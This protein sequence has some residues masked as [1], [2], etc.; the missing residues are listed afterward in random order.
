MPAPLSF[1]PLASAFDGSERVPPL[2]G[3]KSHPS[4]PLPKPGPAAFSS[5][6]N[7]PACFPN[8]LGHLSYTRGNSSPDSILP[9]HFLNS[10]PTRNTVAQQPVSSS[11]SSNMPP[12]HVPR[13]DFGSPTLPVHQ[14]W[15]TFDTALGAIRGAGGRHIDFSSAAYPNFTAI[16]QS[17]RNSVSSTTGGAQ[18]PSRSTEEGPASTETAPQTVDGYACTSSS[19]LG[20]FSTSAEGLAYPATRS[21]ALLPCSSSGLN[22]YQPQSIPQSFRHSFDV[23][24]AGGSP[25]SPTL[26]Q[27]R[28]RASMLEEDIARQHKNRGYY[29]CPVV[30]DSTRSPHSTIAM[31]PP[32]SFPL[33]TITCL[34]AS[35]GQKSYGNEKRFLNPPPMVRVTGSLHRLSSYPRLVVDVVSDNGIYCSREH[36]AIQS[37]DGSTAD[38][39]ARYYLRSLHV[40]K[41][42]KAKTFRL[43]LSLHPSDRPAPPKTLFQ[44]GSVRKAEPIETTEDLNDALASFSSA[45]MQI[46]SKPSKK[47]VRARSTGSCLFDE[48]T[49]ALFNRINAQT[50]RTTFAV[51]EEG[52]LS[53]RAYEWT[54]FKIHV[55]KR[56]EG[57]EDTDHDI[58]HSAFPRNQADGGPEA[59][60]YGSE[61]VL[62]DLMTGSTSE[63]MI[64]RKVE[65]GHVF[66]GA[67]GRVAQLQKLALARVSD[68][69]Y[70]IYLSP[71]SDGMDKDGFSQHTDSYTYASNKPE[72]DPD[73]YPSDDDAAEAKKFLSYQ[74]PLGSLPADHQ[75]KLGYHIV[76]DFMTWTV[77][78][79]DSFSYS[80]FDTSPHAKSPVRMSSLAPITPF[81]L[82][83]SQLT[84]DPLTH[85]CSFAVSDFFNNPSEAEHSPMEIWLGPLGP[86]ATKIIQAGEFSAPSLKSEP[87]TPTSVTGAKAERS[88][89][90]SNPLI[91]R[92]ITSSF[93]SFELP[94]ME[95]ILSTSL[96][97]S[98]ASREAPDLDLDLDPVARLANDRSVLSSS[99]QLLTVGTS[100][101]ALFVPMSPQAIRRDVQTLT[102]HLRAR[103]GEAPEVSR[104]P[105]SASVSRP[106]S[107]ISLPLLFIRSDGIGYQSERSI[108][109]E[110]NPYGATLT[111][112]WSI[113]FT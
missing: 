47:T 104:A 8:G 23:G 13:S 56:A 96:S 21:H 27:K 33:T 46:I 45:E 64:V 66:L 42:G 25:A 106:R 40:G 80:Y 94:P 3:A 24:A 35:V 5:A 53:S 48:S 103:N 15:K 71:S 19:G 51:T 84:Y 60:T 49:I 12:L 72:Q 112:A 36:S 95:A 61:I 86:L 20:G 29:E 68:R 55:T 22:N 34:H 88:N 110:P 31:T 108:V 105:S 83:Q 16:D 43:E 59:V 87:A 41:A 1:P 54:A 58:A 92:Q 101:S 65:K 100:G 52:R 63:P 74:P 75:D 77:V 7:L 2:A 17:R 28:K 26:C 85:T 89:V 10:E 37:D 107:S 111:E 67:T 50:V 81:P 11:L 91:T 70:S 6:S 78:G 76:T 93:I 90:P 30:L 99:P 38:P 32:S 18:G 97:R 79:I 109:L 57:G 102:E 113:S 14:A 39:H 44:N 98:P 9:A 82:V 62:T 73:L 69:G 4:L